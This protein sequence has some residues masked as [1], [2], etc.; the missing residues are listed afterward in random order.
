MNKFS[1]SQRTSH[2]F[3]EQ[4][5]VWQQLRE[6]YEALEKVHTRIVQC[7][8]F[9]VQL[10]YN[11][12]RLVN[13]TANVSENHI[14]QRPCFLCQN[15]RPSEQQ[16]ILYKEEYLILCNPFPIFSPHYTV[17]HFH[18]T[19]QI[20]ENHFEIMLLLAQDFSEYETIF[21]NGAKCGASAPDHFH[22]QIS[23]K[24]KIPIEQEVKNE[25]RKKKQKNIHNIT[26]S[27]LQNVGRSVVVIKGKEINGIKN[28]FFSFCEKLQERNTTIEE[29]KMNILCFYENEFWHVIIFLREKHRPDVFFEEGEKRIL[30]SPAVVDMGGLIITPIEKDFLHVDAK[31]IEQ[32]F[33]EVSLSE[34]VL[35]E[36]LQEL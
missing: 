18:H 32:I 3:I 4:K 30:I 7:E 2:L 15:N 14:K 36:I 28:V 35:E 33:K 24:G 31:I 1:I 11:P 5:K 26:V 6:N 25:Q 12:K 21:Y 22:F 16:S 29:P 34:N 9:T 17:T 20:I 8:G 13:A 19:P 10:Q 23:P 27:V